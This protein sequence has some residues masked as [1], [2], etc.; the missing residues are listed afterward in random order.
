[1]IKS[2]I[3]VVLLL[4]GLCYAAFFLM[5]NVEAKVNLVTF[6]AGEQMLWIGN[7]PA[8]A[9]P[10][11]GAIVGAILMAVAAWGPMVAQRRAAME[12]RA[13]MQKALD[14]FNEQKGRLSARSEEIARLEARLAELE[15]VAP[16]ASP[17]PGPGATAVLAGVG[18]EPGDAA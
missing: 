15:G 16:A 11:L 6:R 3:M 13:K 14:R 4:A 8:G 7:V 18:E 17:A 12:A 5:W 1:M 2:V 10:L 9:L